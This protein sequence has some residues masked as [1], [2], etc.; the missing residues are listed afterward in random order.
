MKVALKKQEDYLLN[1]GKWD[2]K[3]DAKLLKQGGI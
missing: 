2:M 3:T 1:L